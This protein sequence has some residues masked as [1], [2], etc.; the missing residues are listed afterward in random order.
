MGGRDL[1]TGVPEL[2]RCASL[3][4]EDEK[5]QRRHNLPGQGGRAR[6]HPEQPL[7]ARRVSTSYGRRASAR[8]CSRSTIQQVAG[9]GENPL[10]QR[11][12]ET[13]A[14]EMG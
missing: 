7:Q 10:E 12:D 13:L 11:R 4:V 6:A 2:Y 8:P 5:D 1:G 3:E 9:D 14:T